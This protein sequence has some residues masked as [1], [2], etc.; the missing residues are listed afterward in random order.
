M[1]FKKSKKFRMNN[2]AVSEIVASLL[3]LLITVGLFAS[4]IAWVST[5][6]KPSEKTKADIGGELQLDAQSKNG[7]IKLTN[8]RGETLIE[9]NI[10]I[11]I[12]VNDTLI[13][14][15]NISDGLNKKRTWAIGDVWSYTVTNIWNTTKVSIDIIDT[16]GNAM[17]MSGTLQKGYVGS[18][19]PVILSTTAE[20]SVISA[21]G[22]TA[23]FVYV[24][25]IDFDGDLQKTNSV[26][27]N[28]S[29][30]GGSAD[31]PL[32]Y[33]VSDQK[34]KSSSLTV[35]ISISPGN[36]TI[37]IT[38]TDN[39]GNRV[40][41][42]I[43]VIISLPMPPVV[44]VRDRFSNTNDDSLGTSGYDVF[45]LTGLSTRLGTRIFS[46]G[47][48]ISVQVASSTIQN[49]ERENTL[50]LYNSNM[51]EKIE[52]QTKEY[53][54][55]VPETNEPA[56]KDIT[57][58]TERY[59]V[60]EYN[61]TA[62]PSSGYYPFTISL[63]DS[64]GH[65][66]I[67]Y[68]GIY[69]KDPVTGLVPNAPK[70]VTCTEP[71]R[72]GNRSNLVTAEVFNRTDT[73]YVKVLT[74]TTDADLDFVEIGD[75]EI[76]DFRGSQQIKKKLQTPP[77]VGNP[78]IGPIYFDSNISTWE[79]RTGGDRTYT[80]NI[81]LPESRGDPWLYGNNTYILRIRYF[82]DTDEQ[83]TLAKVIRIV[84]PWTTKDIV[85]TVAL[86]NRV[87]SSGVYWYKNG[88]YWY[89]TTIQPKMLKAATALAVGDI[90][91]DGDIDIIVGS[92]DPNDVNLAWFENLKPEGDGWRVHFVSTAVGPD[93]LQYTVES[94]AVCDL[95]GDG[96]GDI[97]AGMKDNT[98][99]DGTG[100]Y[101]FVNDGSWTPIQIV[102]RGFRR[103]EPL[104]IGSSD[105][106]GYINATN[107]QLEDGIT[108]NVTSA[109]N[110]KTLHFNYWNISGLDINN[111]IESVWLYMRY[112]TD[113]GY[114]GSEYVK[115]DKPGV[116][117]TNTTLMPA[118]STADV[119][120][121]YNLTPQGINTLNR[122]QFLN[123]TFHNNDGGN[124]SVYQN[125]TPVLKKTDDNSTKR[126]PYTVKPNSKAANDT[127]GP[128][129][130]V[131][132]NSK[133]AGD[134]TGSA[135]ADLKYNDS[136]YYNVSAGKTLYMDT[137]DT[138]I[139]LDP[140]YNAT[141]VAEFSA[142]AG[143]PG[144]ESML[145]SNGGFFT[146]TNI[147]PASND[148]NRT[149]SYDLFSQGV[150][151]VSELQN[152]DVKFTNGPSPGGDTTCRVNN[153]AP[154]DTAGTN[155]SYIQDNDDNFTQV[156]S[157]DIL[158]VSSFDNAEGL[159]ENFPAGTT[160]T[161]R[162]V[163]SSQNGYN[164]YDKF[165][166]STDNG[167]IW[168]STS[169]AVGNGDND[170][171]RTDDT[172]FD[173]GVTSREKVENLDIKFTNTKTGKWVRA[174]AIQII[175]HIPP[176]TEGVY[177]D[178]MSIIARG[179]NAIS[180]IQND[181]ENK[182]IVNSTQK[183]FLDTFD[184]TGIT[185]TV[186]NA[187]LIIKYSVDIGY[188]G[189]APIRWALNGTELSSTGITPADGDNNKI[190]EFNLFYASVDTLAKINTLNIEFINNDTD[191]RSVRFEYLWLNI[192]AANPNNL[193]TAVTADNITYDVQKNERLYADNFSNPQNIT[194]QEIQS[195][196]LEVR[197]RVT[198]GYD[199]AEY[200]RWA[201]NNQ[202]LQN[203]TIQPTSAETGYVVKYFDLKSANGGNINI[204]ELLA[205]DID[206]INN[207]T[208]N[209]T[210]EFDYIKLN[211]TTVDYQKRVYFDSI[212]IEVTMAPVYG[213][214][215]PT[216]REIKVGDFDN[217]KALDMAAINANGEVRIYWNDGDTNLNDWD[218]GT[219]ATTLPT[220][221]DRIHRL[222]IGYLDGNADNDLDIIA[223]NEYDI[224]ICKNLNDGTPGVK[225]FDTAKN[226]DPNNV[227]S[228][229]I[230]SLAVADM[231]GD[232]R[233]DILVGTI[234]SDRND[235]PQLWLI[236]QPSNGWTAS[237]GNSNFTRIKTTTMGDWI[238]SSWFWDP[239]KAP[240]IQDIAIGDLDGDG[241]L[242]A[243]IG[244]SVG[245]TSWVSMTTNMFVYT[246]NCTEITGN[247]D[248]DG[249][250]GSGAYQYVMCYWEEPVYL[251]PWDRANSGGLSVLNIEIATIDT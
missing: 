68:D 53:N 71:T 164:T 89:K 251:D 196:I 132:P 174:D 64:K 104:G 16:G 142:D 231:D 178:Y 147:Y 80:F 86:D 166:I 17:L 112:S 188:N 239:K 238:S 23:F 133:G 124:V 217:N 42:S 15:F 22:N 129:E 154:G 39:N 131:K 162:V 237:I 180:T 176:G 119:L 193:T 201:L 110:G 46:Q 139:L 30:I 200:I 43:S 207:C 3:T 127:S 229:R 234:M 55:I 144:T 230:T 32:V 75:I 97:I 153:T 187:T 138:G 189:S 168:Q 135:I 186:T 152:L 29:S 7:T 228:K 202:T 77:S 143:Y 192:T 203:T 206:F 248:P 99:T 118:N 137:F 106:T 41:G 84:S 208:E 50:I 182:Y 161:L 179:S 74:N 52:P 67:T 120:D 205:L 114:N 242:D 117:M 113:A 150:D 175:V 63:K 245:R 40:N 45:N 60:Y 156:D 170:N 216:V 211:I 73:I 20:P 88:D 14:T 27:T 121:K 4:V 19:P 25:A 191:N 49:L 10:R 214:S 146:S 116:G 2:T 33:S 69:M 160:V 83:F 194:T 126:A 246:N 244:L 209:C 190:M 48:F 34:Y 236:K 96:D 36:Y 213:G 134:N 177:F 249:Q 82:E 159:P 13:G 122:V 141:L 173:K 181:D 157:T 56:F 31:T 171:I 109:Y 9:E 197:Y 98:D 212:W 123:V 225:S 195:A 38:V 78:P 111:T 103:C 95:D 12:F 105:N 1:S 223:T 79:E 47:E 155:L 66:F 125:S 44:D 108:Y 227:V 235:R 28:L 163:D 91:G 11:R 199:G 149:S 198:P 35:P 222:A 59:Y 148:T 218:V 184:T 185:G 101:V 81:S 215:K 6:E 204:S 250:Y 21:D 61:F 240:R 65:T 54:P 167:T 151:T 221:K 72:T 24:D 140:I 5:L 220:G 243:V 224:F 92:N 145:W 247:I 26:F 232:N 169:I 76:T 130:I 115:F 128:I 62:P 18:N 93:R 100:L 210:V 219:L 87:S 241:D 58:P 165:Y 37:Q 183:M 158:W 70:L 172:L 94:L 57:L 85:A 107:T 226:I 102:E 233:T 136:E 90:D 8:Y 51:L